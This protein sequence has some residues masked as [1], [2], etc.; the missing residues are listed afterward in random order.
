MRRVLAAISKQLRGE[1]YLRTSRSCCIRGAVLCAERHAGERY[2]LEHTDPGARSVFPAP[3]LICS[4]ELIGPGGIR[5][6]FRPGPQLPAA[7]RGKGAVPP[8]L[9]RGARRIRNE[10]KNHEESPTTNPGD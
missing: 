9:V 7:T 6:W 5:R 8:P 3:F 2:Y 1:N 4:R 10:T